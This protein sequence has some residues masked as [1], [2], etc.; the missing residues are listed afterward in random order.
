MP[1]SVGVSAREFHLYSTRDRFTNSAGTTQTKNQPISAHPRCSEFSP[2]YSQ[3]VAARWLNSRNASIWQRAQTNTRRGRNAE[4]KQLPG[5]VVSIESGGTNGC[6]VEVE[7][8]RWNVVE[9]H[10]VFNSWTAARIRCGIGLRSSQERIEGCITGITS[11]VFAIR[12]AFRC[13][14]GVSR[15]CVG[16][17]VCFPSAML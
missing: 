8:R 4:T 15:G 12:P 13:C 1:T 9:G 16:C 3:G 11:A 6:G 7:R 5:Q 14:L 2:R 10:G 17:T